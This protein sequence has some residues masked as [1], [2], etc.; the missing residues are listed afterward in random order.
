M[1]GALIF[2]A[3]SEINGGELHMVDVRPHFH[4]PVHLPTQRRGRRF[5]AG[6]GNWRFTVSSSAIVIR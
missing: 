1:R 6:R 3:L 5:P 2:A 4:Q